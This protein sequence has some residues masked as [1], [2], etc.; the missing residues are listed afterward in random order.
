MSGL[1]WLPLKNLKNKLHL[2]SFYTVT[3]NLLVGKDGIEA[4]H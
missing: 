2:D 1:T 4:D 3:I